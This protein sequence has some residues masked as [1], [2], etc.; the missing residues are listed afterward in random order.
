MSKKVECD[1]LLPLH[2]PQFHS[3]LSYKVLTMEVNKEKIRFILQ[4][5][6][7]NGENA[8]Q[9]AEIM[10][11]VYSAD[12]VTA[13]YVQFWFR[14]LRSGIFYVK[15]ATRIGRPVVKNVDK[16]TEIIEVDRH[17]N[18]RNIAQELKIDHKT[19]LNHLRKAGFKKKLD[20]R[21]SHQL[22]PKNMMDGISICEVLAKRNEIDPFLKRMV[23]GDKK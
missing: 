22:A 20:F 3:V 18:S 10:N 13:N 1:S 5:F 2:C 16:I 8:S 14:R 23:T 21:V 7:D 9:A 15:D 19:V 12:T 11:G 4:F 6:F 17:V